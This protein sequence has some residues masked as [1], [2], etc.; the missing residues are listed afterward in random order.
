M[1]KTILL[2][3]FFV[4]IKSSYSQEIT[5]S[6][7]LTDKDSV[8]IKN[9]QNYIAATIV[10]SG[11]ELVKVEKEKLMKAQLEERGLKL[12]AIEGVTIQTVH[13][14]KYPDFIAT[15]QN[16]V[17]FKFNS[18]ELSDKALTILEK[19]NGIIAEMPGTKIKIIGHTDNVGEKDYNDLLSKNRASSVGNYFR[20]AG[21]E[22]QLIEEIGKGFAEPVASNKSESGRS[23]NR[24][25]EITLSTPEA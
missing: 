18:I 13:N 14:N 7:T 4:V 11:A 25:V 24:R 2:I 16:D 22:N 3:L 23:K 8:L 20:N 10:G 17:L 1:K 6:A 19:L 12:N 21:I 15:V 5:H 9:N